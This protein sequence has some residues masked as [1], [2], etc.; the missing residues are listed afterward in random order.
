VFE[1][2]S[3]VGAP[4]ITATGAPK[5]SPGGMFGGGGNQPKGDIRKLW[6]ALEID[7][8]GQPSMQGMFNPELVW[9]PFNPYPNLEAADQLWLF[10]DDRL[11]EGQQDLVSD[12][13]LI[14]S[15]I[16]QVLA[17][18]AGGV[19]PKD[20][21]E[22]RHTP[23]L[24]TGPISGTLSAETVNQVR[25]GQTT[26]TREL[27]SINPF[28]PIAMTIQ[29]PAG[30]S[31]DSEETEELSGEN[32]SSDAEPSP[33]MKVVYVADTDIILPEFLLIRADPDQIADLKFQFKNV[34][35]ALNT[36]DWLTGETS[37][38]DV[39]G[40]EPSIASLRM[41]DSVKEVANEQVRER[42]SDFQRAFEMANLE[43]EEKMDR[44]LQ[45]LREELQKLEKERA[46]GT[47]PSSV[48]R[49]KTTAFQIKQEN[50]QRMLAV[51]REKMERERDQKIRDVRRTAEQQ[52]TMIQN[53]VKVAAVVLPCIPPLIIGIMVFASRRLRERENIS[54][55]RLK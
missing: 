13:S 29:S 47:V 20:E 31:S 16:N 33:G 27:D 11:G 39:R 1:D 49:E 8:P 48:I 21:S 10:I 37:F 55:S 35:F 43:A 15:S 51:R 3:P 19:Y 30:E 26:L 50:Q 41:I 53:R 4:Y 18:H 14:T 24:S 23:L 2:P 46:D 42:A 6:D 25:T 38:I 52:V 28:V 32:A 22:L 54:K 9:Q 36:I 7:V 5:Q 12:D 34:T 45:S 44:E 40:H 17:I